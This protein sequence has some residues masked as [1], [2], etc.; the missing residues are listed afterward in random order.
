MD[1]ACT[2]GS[3][4]PH[5]QTETAAASDSSSSDGELRSETRQVVSDACMTGMAMTF[6]G[7]GFCPHSDDASIEAI[8]LNRRVLSAYFYQLD[9]GSRS[10][11]A[12]C[13]PRERQAVLS[14]RSR[15]NSGSAACREG[16]DQCRGFI[17]NL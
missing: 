6:G 15:E 9:S 1:A 14:R 12:T 8:G 10:W 13:T 11:H 5:V 4:L 3:L 7:V 16:A 17:Q 2:L